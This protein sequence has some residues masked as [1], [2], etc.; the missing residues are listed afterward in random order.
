MEESERF[1]IVLF[2]ATAQA[3]CITNIKIHHF[4]APA[5]YDCQSKFLFCEA[6]FSMVVQYCKE[7]QRRLAN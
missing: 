7:S 5:G 4:E 1:D 3:E 2:L 6:M